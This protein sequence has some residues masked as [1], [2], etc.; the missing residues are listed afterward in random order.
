MKSYDANGL[1][2][3]LEISIGFSKWIKAMLKNVQILMNHKIKFP[4]TCC[5]FEMGLLLTS[6]FENKW[7]PANKTEQE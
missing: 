3:F 6:S 7:K 1:M 4:W 5:K 2:I